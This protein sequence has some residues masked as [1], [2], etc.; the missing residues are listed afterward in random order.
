MTYFVDVE[1]AKLLE[2]RYK[3]TIERTPPEF[4]K[5]L[6]AVREITLGEMTRYNNMFSS[7]CPLNYRYFNCSN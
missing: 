3:T 2:E 6:P 1:Q 4:V 7:A 5:P